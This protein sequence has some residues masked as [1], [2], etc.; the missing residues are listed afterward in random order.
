MLAQSPLLMPLGRLV[1]MQSDLERAHALYASRI[2]ALIMIFICGRCVVRATF[3]LDAIFP[4]P[5]LRLPMSPR[6]AVRNTSI[7]LI[8]ISLLMVH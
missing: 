6:K 1:I 4:L 5:S 3:S 8:G 7:D 2:Y